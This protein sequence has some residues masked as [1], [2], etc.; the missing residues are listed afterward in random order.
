MIVVNKNVDFYSSKIM[1]KNRKGN[2]AGASPYQKK[3]NSKVIVF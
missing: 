3:G 2:F 1:C